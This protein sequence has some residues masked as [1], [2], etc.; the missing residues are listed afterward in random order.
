MTSRGPRPL[1]LQPPSP[2]RAARGRSS[3]ALPDDLLTSGARRLRV[4]AIFGLVACTF[5]L[6]MPY[7][8]SAG[9]FGSAD[10]LPVR[11][12]ILAVALALSAA[13]LVATVLHLDVKRVLNLGLLWYALECGLLAATDSTSRW[14]AHSFAHGLPAPC[15][16]V[17]I[18]PVLIPTPPRRF[19]MASLLALALVALA[20]L[21]VPGLAGNPPAGFEVIALTLIPIAVTIS[22]A[23]VAAQ[24]IYRLG[25]DL[26]K[27]RRLGSYELVAPLGKGGMGE[28]WRAH[29]GMLA[30]EAAIKLI[31]RDRLSDDQAAITRFQNEA[32]VVASLRSPHT[33]QVW[34][35]GVTG[36]GALYYAMELL[37]GMDFDRLVGDYGPQ[38]PERV[39]HF[40][41]Q[42]CHSL[43]EA[44]AAGLAHRDIK[45]ANLFTAR[46]GL[47]VDVVKLL[48]FGLATQPLHE[49]IDAR[50]TS[51]GMVMGTPAYMA[52]EQVMGRRDL[53]GRADLYSLGAVGY[54]LLTGRDV[55]LGENAT[56]VM[57]AHAHVE[58]EPPSQHAKEPIPAALER[59]ILRCLAKKPADRFQSADELADALRAV[60][61]ATPWTRERAHAWWSSL[62]KGVVP[63]AT[64]PRAKTLADAEAGLAQTID[65]GPRLEP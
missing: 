17:L 22:V 58:P 37:A 59:V 46:L 9:T 42:A 64:L 32:R 24:V 57:F 60:T 13:L 43:A 19:L 45:P 54:F 5:A 20:L 38:P 11:S 49:K 15:V 47:D 12:A 62:A 63:S 27:A 51:D 48:D 33:I 8:S 21:V 44:H 6:V 10:E 39:A 55:F 4:V 35:Y 36:D 41:V 31:R 53:D 52:P 2:S 56:Q 65:L 61:F 30:R 50:I 3:S 28:V 14:Q 7:L 1:I 16:L 25:R 26:K 23:T 29:H 18:F 34:D 40:L